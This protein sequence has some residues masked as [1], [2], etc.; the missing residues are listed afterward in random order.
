MSIRSLTYAE[1]FF[2]VKY[3]L[4]EK[5]YTIGEKCIVFNLSIEQI[6]INNRQL[7]FFRSVVVTNSPI[8]QIKRC[9]IIEKFEDYP[10]ENALFEEVKKAWTLAYDATHEGRHKG[11]AL[12]R[13]PKIEIGDVEVNMCFAGSIPL[14]AGL[15]QS[16]WGGPPIKEVHTQ[17]V[18]IG[19]MQQCYKQDVKSLYREE[20]MAPGYS[21]IPM[22]DEKC[23]YPWHQYET[24][25]KG[26]FMATEMQRK[27]FVQT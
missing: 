2:P 8:F 4:D 27:A 24:I 15:H 16:H 5:E 6:L 25:T 13:S 10:D 20:P 26:I 22:Y 23:E 11:V 14:R 12:W 21:H 7:D 18:G 9:L 19:K 1:P 17:I 3:I